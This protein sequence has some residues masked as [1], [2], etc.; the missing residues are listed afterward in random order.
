MRIFPEYGG[1][2][3]TTPD[4]YIE[5]PPELIAE[6]AYSS[7][8]I[9]LH[10]KRQDYTRYGV[11]EYLVLSLHEQQLRWFDLR[12]DKE[13]VLDPDGICRV[14]SFPGLWIHA[15]GL[16][17]KNYPQLIATLQQGLRSPEHAEFVKRVAAK[18]K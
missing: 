17:Q 16:L 2:S 10:A 18:R 6:I 12:G 4:D 3:K 5:G 1:Q 11:W 15:E 13:L 7:N 8:A 14:R 9:D